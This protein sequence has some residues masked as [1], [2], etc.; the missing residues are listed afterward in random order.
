[1]ISCTEN[2]YSFIPDPFGINAG[3]YKTY[4]VD[5]NGDNVEIFNAIDYF[6][7]STFNPYDTSNVIPLPIN[8]SE[9]LEAT[10]DFG[11]ENGIVSIVLSSMQIC[12]TTVASTNTSFDIV[13]KGLDTILSDGSPSNIDAHFINQTISFLASPPNPP[14]N[15]FVHCEGRGNYSISLISV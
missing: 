9:N 5:I 15:L 2:L 7:D 3:I 13:T 10:F 8:G 6:V 14:M 4:L 12:T 11:T 1:M